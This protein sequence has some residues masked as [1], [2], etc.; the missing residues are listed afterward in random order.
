MPCSKLDF[1]SH[2]AQKGVVKSINF[3]CEKIAESIFTHDKLDAQV[4]ASKIASSF[5]MLQAQ[6]G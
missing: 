6:N 5:S 1:L 3:V 2:F 4:H